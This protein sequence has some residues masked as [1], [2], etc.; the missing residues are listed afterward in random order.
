MIEVQRHVPK[1]SKDILSIVAGHGPL[2]I[3]LLS[4]LME[5]AMSKRNIRKTLALL[6]KKGLIDAA[7]TNPHSV[8]YF[9]SQSMIA[10]TET[11]AALGASEEN[12]ERPLLR[13]QDWMH[14]QWCEYW[15]S[16]LAKAY[17]EARFVR[18]LSARTDVH[19]R[20]ILALGHEA[21]DLVPDFLMIF[22]GSQPN[23]S[24]CIAFEI[25]RTRKSNRRI[26]QKL[27]KYITSTTV[28]GLIYI[29]DSGRL[30][31]TVRLLYQAQLDKR[32]HR[33]AHYSDHFF[34]F[35][36]S[37]DG[38][39]TSFPRMFNSHA[40][41]VSLEKWIRIIRET[42]WTKRRDSDFKNLVAVPD[43]QLKQIANSKSTFPQANHEIEEAARR[44]PAPLALRDHS[45][46]TSNDV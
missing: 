36:D 38:G 21:E 26:I 8:Y 19:V 22:H 43:S 14:N 37:M 28:D 27:S 32:A 10:R 6:R 15:I 33:I 9:T 29:C 39:G 5:P 17:P 45:P 44:G 1:R 23:N 42:K 13:K 4:R 30:S 41:S 35:S 31:E 3:D 40:Q 20:R 25:E 2:T 46:P 11:A 12:F 24:T 16:L 7:A 34:I 18:E